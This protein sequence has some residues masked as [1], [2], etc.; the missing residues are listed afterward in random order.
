MKLYI[1][2]HGESETNAAN[3]LPLD[4]TDLTENGLQH[5]AANAA[6]LAEKGIEAIHASPLLRAQKTAEAISTHTNVPV[7]YHPNLRDTH[8]GSLAGLLHDG[9]LTHVTEEM[10]KRE[11]NRVHHKVGGGES[12][13]DVQVRVLPI[14]KHITG[15]GHKTAAVVAHLDVNR[16]LLAELL[17]ISLE[18]SARIEQHNDTIYE[19][20]A[21]SKKVHYIR[22]GIRS[23]GLLFKH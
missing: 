19:V 11:E 9:T 16:I 1:V 7:T 18:D 13:H 6:Y 8:F 10:K 23:E 15:N 22:N 20:D 2:R 17:G 14:L 4:T 3:C 5:A 12:Y 21:I